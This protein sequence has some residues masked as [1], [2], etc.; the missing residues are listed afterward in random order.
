MQKNSMF[1]PESDNQ[2]LASGEQDHTGPAD[3]PGTRGARVGHPAAFTYVHALSEN[4]SFGREVEPHLAGAAISLPPV[5]GRVR[6]T[7]SPRH[8]PSFGYAHEDSALNAQPSADT[9]VVLSR[10]TL[11][12]RVVHSPISENSLGVGQKK[13]PKRA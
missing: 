5:Y 12:S 1:T 13:G 8:P 6:P 9:S 7:D 3:Q 10:D 4:I 2:T 11:F